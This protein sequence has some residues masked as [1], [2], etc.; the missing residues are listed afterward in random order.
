[1]TIPESAAGKTVVVWATAV[2]LLTMCFKRN[3]ENRILDQALIF[4][5]LVLS[6]QIAA[7][8][9][10]AWHGHGRLGCP[11]ALA[12]WSDAMDYPHYMV[13]ALKCER[14]HVIVIICHRQSHVSLPFFGRRFLSILED[15]NFCR[16]RFDTYLSP[17]ICVEPALLYSMLI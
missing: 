2:S 14:T 7:F 12:G 16:A 4:G 8:L 5:I 13:L 3:N 6:K 11:E 1:M 17:D 10:L 9:V 15:V